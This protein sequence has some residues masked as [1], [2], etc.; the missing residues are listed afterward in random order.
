VTEEEARE[1]AKDHPGIYVSTG[2]GGWFFSARFHATDRVYYGYGG[3]DTYKAVKARKRLIRKYKTTDRLCFYMSRAMETDSMTMEDAI[4]WAAQHPGIF[5]EKRRS[6]ST[7]AFRVRL[8]TGGAY[9]SKYCGQSTENALKAYDDMVR[10]SSKLSRPFVK[11]AKGDHGQLIS[12][13]EVATI[14]KVRKYA[15]THNRSMSDIVRTMI[16]DW[17]DGM[18]SDEVWRRAHSLTEWEIGEI[19]RLLQNFKPR[20]LAMIV[21]RLQEQI[22]GGAKSSERSTTVLA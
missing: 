4:A 9:F 20:D 2:K 12:I 6:N 5:V 21:V 7:W 22:H 11:L 3:R 19:E 15:S 17:L 18:S 14:D 16:H 13:V 8:H 1:W 10:K